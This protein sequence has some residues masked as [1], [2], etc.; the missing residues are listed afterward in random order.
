MEL[1]KRTTLHYQAERSDKIYE[2]DL[3]RV[4]EELY[5]INF[6][7]GRRGSQL[8]EGT[9]TDRPVS[10]AE[11]WTVLEQLIASKI[12][13]GYRDISD[14]PKTS[15]ISQSQEKSDPRQEAILNR[16]AGGGN[17][18]WPLERAI[19]RAGELKISAAVPLLVKLIGTGVP[20]RDYCIAW[21]LGWCGDLSAFA[22]LKNLNDISQP[23]FVRRIAWE[24]LYKLAD[25]PERAKMREQKLEQLPSEL[26]QFART[27]S[28]VDFAWQLHEYLGGGYRHFDVLDLLYQIDSDRIRPVLLDFLAKA[29]LVPNCFKPIRH[30]FKM[31][32]YR[33]DAEVFAIIAYRFETNRCNFDNPRIGWVWDSRRRKYYRSKKRRYADEL[34]K[35]DT[36]KAYSNQTR[37]YLRRRIWRTLR[38]LGEEGDRDYI[39][40]AVE[41]LLQYTDS[42]SQPI[43]ESSFTRWD[44]AAR[45]H[46]SLWRAWDAY[47]GYI[48]FGH[49]LYENSPRYVLIP[50]SKAWRCREN[51]DPGNPEP[52]EREEAFPDLWN[53]HPEALLRLLLA[54]NCGPVHHFA[55][56]ALRANQ[57]FCAEFDVDILV[58]L[59]NRPYE[60]TAELGFDL[61]RERYQPNNANWE[62]LLAL[63]NCSF[64]PGRIQ[65][66]KW[67][68][69]EW[70]SLLTYTQFVAALVVSPHRDTRAFIRRLLAEASPEDMTAKVLIGRIIA[71]LLD[72]GA[73]QADIAR[74]AGDLL[75]LIFTR[76]LKSLSLVVVQDLLQQP[77]LEIQELGAWIVLTHHMRAADLPPELIESLLESPYESIR[78]IG[79]NLFGELPEET[80]AGE[81]AT[82]IAAMAIS[83]IADIRSSVQPIIIRLAGDRPD[84]AIRIAND[85]IEILLV[86]EKHEGVHKDIVRLM[87]E[88]LPEWMSAINKETAMQLLRAKS[89]QARELA[90]AILLARGQDWAAATSKENEF[91]TFEIV[92][93]AN[94][95]IL[96]VRQAAW[97]MFEQIEE[98]IRSSEK[99]KLA[100]VR[101]LE[102]KWQ[103]SQEFALKIFKTRFSREDWSPEVLVAICD[104]IREEVRQFGRELVE[105]H[106]QESYGQDYLLK[107]SEHPSGDMQLFAANYLEK[108]ATE[109]CERLREMM[110]YFIS[111][112]TQV[113]R[114]RVAKQRVFDF[115]ETEASKSEESARVIAEVL[116]RQS[117]TIAIGDRA[118]AIQ[119]MLKIHKA[120]PEIN[121]PIKVLGVGCRV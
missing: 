6:R 45:R 44:S 109:N 83:A 64:E 99:E 58:E 71:Q 68:E 18:K 103:D 34:K 74:D 82:L 3:C 90:G 86:P 76:E 4:G 50:G 49:I 70:A 7:Y 8:K 40:L 24:A 79:M 110:P 92:K 101:L 54:S 55:V 47:A 84:F 14:R 95:E 29:D 56:K 72:L 75:L 102:A 65:G 114:G 116:G 17:Q 27:A 106:F 93:L 104:S 105:G 66:Y 16:L 60:V 89:P 21:A 112:L 57:Q 121:L 42:D 48:T 20:L 59:L 19:W 52:Q 11:A 41:I 108:Y 61:A 120:Y 78:E 69:E 119:I 85:L 94:N 2:V 87:R 67:I 113:N 118:K 117:A 22:P 12:K 26:R 91:E 43:K 15:E 37:E 53:R 51:Y 28:S 10:L 73:E 63:A 33:R 46:R 23:D 77:M 107:F 1:I 13:G 38:H 100:A 81:H 39:N 115:L 98:R 35:P 32:E 25:E 9:K 30:I 36:N 88:Q 111:V 96:S 62:L 97:G 31:A 5:I 80:L